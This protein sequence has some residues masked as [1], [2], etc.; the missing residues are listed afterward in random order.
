MGTLW[1]NLRQDRDPVYATQQTFFFKRINMLFD[2]DLWDWSLI[3]SIYDLR[4]MR[5]L[6]TESTCMQCCKT[7]RMDT[8]TNFGHRRWLK[9]W[10]NGVVLFLN[11][12][13]SS[14]CLTVLFFLGFTR[15][16][17]RLNESLKQILKP[18]EGVLCFHFRVCL[19]VCPSV[20][21]SVP[22]LQS[23]PF[24]LGT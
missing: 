17:D 18:W 23:T 5:V 21:L 16:Q 3:H 1:P 11:L 12:D 20:R 19:S 24:D 9:N 2:K 14:G 15:D 13:K 22:E 10:T 4:Y 6:K 7:L 8:N